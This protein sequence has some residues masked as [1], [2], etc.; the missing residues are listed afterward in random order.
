MQFPADLD[1]FTEEIRNGKL[2]F[3]CSLLYARTFL[4]DSI[5]QQR[6]LCENNTVLIQHHYWLK[7]DLLLLQ[8]INK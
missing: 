8:T 6:Y 2:H 4:K 3:L 5:K 1:I 7:F